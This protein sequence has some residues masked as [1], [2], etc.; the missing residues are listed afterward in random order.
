M[1]WPP[2]RVDLD[3]IVI[4]PPDGRR[5]FPTLDFEPLL[6]SGGV[7]QYQVAQTGSEEIEVRLVA[8]R[9]LKPEEEAEIGA[10]LQSNFRHPFE[11]RFVYVGEIARGPGGKFQIFRSELA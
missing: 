1:T 5:L 10:W 4:G 2:H 3:S 9:R 7:R 8:E 11:V 6:L